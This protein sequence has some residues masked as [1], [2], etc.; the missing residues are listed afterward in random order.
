LERLRS[1]TVG[2]FLTAGQGEPYPHGAAEAVLLSL[3][4]A[5]GQDAAGALC[6][7][8]MEIV[9]VLSPAGAP[10]SLLHAAA[11]SG[12]LPGCAGPSD[13]RLVDEAV[14]RLAGGSLLTFSGES[15]SV[16]AA[17]R[18]TMRVVRERAMREAALGLLGTRACR[19][20][21]S[22]AELLSEPWKDQ[23]A[24][25]DL[26]GHAAS[27]HRHLL[28]CLDDAPALETEL[29]S[30][31]VTALRWLNLLGGAPAEAVEQGRS[32]LADSERL[33]GDDEPATLAARL[34][35]GHAFLEAGRSAEAIPVLE[36]A[37]AGSGQ[38]PGDDA[39]V[40][41][42]RG[43]LAAAYYGAGLLDDAVCL[44]ERVLADSE[45]ILGDG[46]IA[47][48]TFRSSL[49]FAYEG[50]GRLDDAIRLYERVLADSEGVQGD[51]HLSALDYRNSLAPAYRAAGRLDAA[52]PLYERA[53]ADSER[54]LG[55]DHPGTLTARSNLAGAY[56]DA[57]RFNEAIL[58]LE[59]VLAEC[60][61]VLGDDH[62]STLA[63]GSNLAATREAAGR[64]SGKSAQESG[65]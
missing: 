57:G 17:H 38:V 58:L 2:E 61:R 14:G 49:A 1:V 10:R 36:R 19:L 4:A 21:A 40:L 5:A 29:L 62:P 59:R 64:P 20:L 35:L 56:Y 51:D 53:L 43:N 44:Y 50:S 48:L 24:A 63:V 16:V 25:R 11:A 15:D 7:S 8:V 23:G 32:V 28:P 47:T 54:I 39:S 34:G 18:L 45:R 13:A 27:L 65:S 31:R 55:D 3:D 6:R 30:L 12:A 33:L 37:L 9:S 52:I 60:E 22:V 42:A 26:I 41:D 46:H